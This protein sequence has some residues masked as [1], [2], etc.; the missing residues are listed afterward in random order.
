MRTT[1]FMRRLAWG[2]A[3]IA[4]VASACGTNRTGSESSQS[5]PSP[6]QVAST[7]STVT[8]DST[9]EKVVPGGD[10]ECAD[11]SEFAFFERRA[12]SKKVVFFLDGGGACFDAK[13]CAFTGLGKP[14]EEN[15]D[16]KVTDDP[17]EEGGIL[18]FARA[19]NPFL[20]YSFLYVPPAPVTHTSATSPGCTRPS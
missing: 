5:S 1:R 20:D 2:T 13:T 12:D 4:I 8:D 9:W 10:C 14:G 18:D 3:A 11:G 7:G 15:Y 6:S 17:A 19:D 16:W